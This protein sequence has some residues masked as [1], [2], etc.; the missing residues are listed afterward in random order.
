MA[1]PTERARVV[2]RAVRPCRARRPRA[3]PGWFP[4]LGPRLRRAVFAGTTCLFVLHGNVHD[5]IRLGD[6]DGRDLRQPRR[7]PGD[8]ALRHVGRRAAARPEP[9]TP[10]L[11]GPTPSGCAGWSRSWRARIGEPKSW[12]RD[13][14]ADP[15]ACSTS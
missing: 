7:I 6:C 13:P 14:D 11:A 15:R 3:V 12:P 8:A 2:V 1:T 10:P 4:Q 5:L 9:G